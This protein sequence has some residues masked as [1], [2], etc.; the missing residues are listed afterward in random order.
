[1]RR[2]DHTRDLVPFGVHALLVCDIVKP[3]NFS[4]ERLAGAR[5]KNCSAEGTNRGSNRRA[6][7]SLAGG[8]ADR[9]SQPCPEDRPDSGAADSALRS[10]G[11][12]RGSD[13]LA[14][15]IPAHGVIGLELLEGLARARQDHHAWARGH[16]RTAD[17]SHH[18]SE[19]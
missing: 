16:G 2:A 6:G 13:L 12:G 11:R 18:H 10:G 9:R 14:R 3:L 8:S 1:L 19:R 15:P 4:S 17:Q 5:P 7:A